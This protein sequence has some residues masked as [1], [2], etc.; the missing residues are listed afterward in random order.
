M[1]T[2]H[3]KFGDG[4]CDLR[5]GYLEVPFSNHF[6]FGAGEDYTIEMF[7]YWDQW[8]RNDVDDKVFD[9]YVRCM[10]FITYVVVSSLCP[11]LLVFGIE[12]CMSAF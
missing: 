7:L 1:D 10:L 12:A 4:S 2:T 3:P 6:T 9:G 11:E 8:D 5:G